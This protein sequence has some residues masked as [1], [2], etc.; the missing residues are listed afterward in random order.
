MKTYQKIVVPFLEPIVYPPKRNK[1][2][3][4]QTIYISNIL[5]SC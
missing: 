4:E 3:I 2:Y 5:G 1:D